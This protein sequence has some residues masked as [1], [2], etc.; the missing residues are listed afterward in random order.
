MPVVRSQGPTVAR[1]PLPRSGN[2]GGAAAIDTAARGVGFIAERIGR[3]IQI[4]DEAVTAE[5]ELAYQSELDR[6][7]M[8]PKTGVLQV[9]GARAL[10]AAEKLREQLPQITDRASTGLT[11]ERQREAFRP[12]AE[13][14]T[15]AAMLRVDAHVGNELER[16]RQ[17]THAGLLASDRNA[18][19]ELARLGNAAGV[20]DVIQRMSRR[21]ALNGDASGTAP[22]LVAQERT[23]AISAGRTLQIQSLL[24]SRQ[25]PQAAAVFE[26][27]KA[28]L[29]TEARATVE[30]WLKTGQT[31]HAA[32]RAVAEI[33]SR[34]VDSR[35][36]LE[37]ELAKIADADVRK[38]AR[39]IV[40]TELKRREDA[41]KADQEAMY[42]QA[43]LFIDEAGPGV[44]F[45]QAVPLTVR[46][47]LSADQRRS[48][49]TR[50]NAPAENNAAKWIEFFGMDPVER[51]KL[52]T[53]EFQT[54]YWQHFDAAHRSRAET[55]LASSRRPDD[56]ED[57]RTFSQQVENTAVIARIR[58]GAGTLTPSQAREYA[59]FVD[60]AAREMD[61]L[62]A[63][64]KRL[65]FPERQ[66]VLDGLVREKR[67]AAAGS[68]DLGRWELDE[69]TRG[70]ATIPYRDLERDPM[71]IE[72]LRESV[73]S[74]QQRG[75]RVVLDK[76]TLERLGAATYLGD[77][78]RRRAILYPE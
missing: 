3:E 12:R 10:E 19:G 36:M 62:Q 22:E 67:F 40:D 7:L 33:F 6:V 46:Q 17:E 26:Q 53:V 51:A 35:T 50:T 39:A 49:Q 78:T 1:A 71:F 31:E 14:M 41:K 48:L 9:R 44:S 16:T 4:A 47:M 2:D 28:Q 56:Q 65:T 61:V 45:E 11:A 75:S 57:V 23:E 60:L 37:T 72:A 21:I 76:P 42:E 73:R 38:A 64:G 18:L 30:D 63:G 32:A 77:M 58:P 54:K 66:A 27:H 24:N 74:A 5:A 25:I 68:E 34:G 70:I 52:T 69:D 43:A 59:Q 13:A 55:M 29:T 20:D 8:D 15:R